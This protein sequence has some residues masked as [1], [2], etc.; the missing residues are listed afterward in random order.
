ML[1]C[2]DETSIRT[3]PSSNAV[4]PWLGW[5]YFSWRR[6]HYNDILRIHFIS[7]FILLWYRRKCLL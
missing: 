5:S 2:K 7:K 6:V 1:N 4:L 3:I